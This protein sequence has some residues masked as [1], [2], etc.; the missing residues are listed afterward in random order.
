MKVCGVDGDSVW[1]EGRSFES[2]PLC[3]Y[4]ASL[5]NESTNKYLSVAVD[6]CDDTWRDGLGDCLIRDLHIGI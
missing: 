1:C 5:L 2:R 4:F 3:L 6:G